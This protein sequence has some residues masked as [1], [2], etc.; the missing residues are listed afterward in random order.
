MLEIRYKNLKKGYS[1]HVAMNT[2]KINVRPAGVELRMPPTNKREL[3]HEEALD[4]VRRHLGE[5]KFVGEKSVQ[6][7]ANY[8]TRHHVDTAIVCEGD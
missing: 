4:Q 5:E 2:E 3:T 7:R 1:E 6:M 8:S